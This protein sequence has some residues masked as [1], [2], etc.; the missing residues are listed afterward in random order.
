VT[1][2]RIYPTGEH[3]PAGTV[4]WEVE[5]IELSKSAQKRHERDDYEHDP[6]VD[7]VTHYKIFQTEAE[8]KAYAVTVRD[9]N[10]NLSYGHATVTKQIAGRMED[11]PPGVGEWEN[12]GE[13][14][15]VD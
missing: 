6:D 2:L 15:Y 4:R 8:A 9:S 12:V 10:Q 5:W 11:G 14:E 1:H 3:V 7:D 13:P